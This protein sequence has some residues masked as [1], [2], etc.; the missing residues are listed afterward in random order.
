[1]YKTVVLSGFMIC[2]S[3][4]TYYAHIK[5]YYPNIT[6]VNKHTYVKTNDTVQIDKNILK[7]NDQISPYQKR[8]FKFVKDFIDAD[9]Y[10]V[11]DYSDRWLPSEIKT[12]EIKELEI[13]HTLSPHNKFYNTKQLIDFYETYTKFIQPKTA[14]E[15]LKDEYAFMEEYFENNKIVNTT[16][17][18][19]CLEEINMFISKSSNICDS[20]D[21]YKF[22][23]KLNKYPYLMYLNN[24]FGKYKITKKYVEINDKQMLEIKIYTTYKF[25]NSPNSILIFYFDGSLIY[26]VASEGLCNI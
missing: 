18:Y 19:P 2:G 10:L 12:L 21:F 13:L 23:V 8:P 24:I 6:L 4:Y 11:I 26:K 5:K 16:N 25:W 14:H 22:I 3:Y 9:K 20:N 7:K 15:L 17:I 1:M